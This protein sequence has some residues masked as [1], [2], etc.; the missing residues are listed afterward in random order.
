[1]HVQD[2]L[3]SK[4]VQSL[5]SFDDDLHNNFE[6]LEDSPNADRQISDNSNL[7]GNFI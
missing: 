4:I 2:V 7:A 3:G 5:Q 6:K 1:M